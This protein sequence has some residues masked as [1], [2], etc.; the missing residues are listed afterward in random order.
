MAINYGF[1][2]ELE[3]AEFVYAFVG[4]IQYQFDD[5]NYGDSDYPKYPIE[6]LW[7][8]SGDCEDAAILFIAMVELLGYDAML[9]IGEVKSDQD[10][11]WGGHAWAL[12]HIPNHNGDGWYGTGDKSNI[13]FYW[14]EATSHHDGISEIGLDPWFEV[15]IQGMYDVESN[16]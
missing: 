5:I 13:P 3:I 8:Q 9:A 11:D 12:I 6:M 14:V 10:D 15:D 2:S 7:D 1:T 4:D 16:W